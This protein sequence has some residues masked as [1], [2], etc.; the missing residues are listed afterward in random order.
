MWIIGK[1][2][3][4]PGNTEMHVSSAARLRVALHTKTKESLNDKWMNGNSSLMTNHITVSY[5]LM[6]NTHMAHV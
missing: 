2:I 4:N 1:F 3:Q 6:I 5:P